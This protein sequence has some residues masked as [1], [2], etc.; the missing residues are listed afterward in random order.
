MTAVETPSDSWKHAIG[1][2]ILQGCILALL[3]VAIAWFV[4][5]PGRFPDPDSFYHAGMAE[6]AADGVFRQQFPWLTLTGF[7][8]RYADLHLVY[9]L[10][11]VPFVRLFGPADG[12]RIAAIAAIGLLTV[13]FYAML[14]TMRVRGAFWFTY[15]LL[16]SAAFMFRANLAK[17]QGF[18]FFILFLG[19]AAAAKRSYIGIFLAALFAAWTSSHWPVL[20]A[21]IGCIALAQFVIALI[22]G[23][24]PTF[25][26]GRPFLALCAMVLTALLGNV[27]AMIVHPYFPANLVV[28]R[29]QILAIAVIGG[30]PESIPGS[31]W[32]PL[33]MAHLLGAVGF[34]IPLALAAIGGLLTLLA[35]TVR[36]TLPDER[37]TA[38]YALAIG[39]LAAGFVV[40]ALAAQRHIEFLVPLAITAIALGMQPL[41]AW[42]WPPRIAIAWRRPGELRRPLSSIVLFV[43][44]VAFT[45]GGVRGIM[46]QRAV[47]AA[48]HPTETLA[49]ASGWIAEHAPPGA[50]IFHAD[51]DDFPFL[52]F[53][54]RHQRYLVGLDPRFAYFHDRE[55]YMEMLAIRDA[56]TTAGSIARRIVAATD[57]SYALTTN[58][59]TA[60]IALLNADRNATK[61]YADDEATV[62]ELG[63]SY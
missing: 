62:Y 7:P 15:L 20:T 9:H 17:S 43:A 49:A 42:A 2:P 23:A 58:D 60:L 50:I 41:I 22:D 8:D 26:I 44:I 3:A 31:E 48:G 46:A 10:I 52:F 4:Q 57:A 6:L 12:I 59:Q 27:V 1:H 47:F 14:R 61:V 13:G 40:L 56:D 45:I 19:I 36:G 53:H 34:L 33:S 28:A 54:N 35:R 32:A 16:G 29:E 11:L 18:A 24:T 39:L 30:I 21:A 55:R 5:V 25:R 63:K 38:A 51:W 37:R